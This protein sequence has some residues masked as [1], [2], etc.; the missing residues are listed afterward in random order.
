MEL[1]TTGLFGTWSRPG[2]KDS[3][4]RSGVEGPYVFKDNEDPGKLVLLLDYFGGDGYRPFEGNVSALG[5]GGWTDVSRTNWPT[6]L[7]HGSVV[8]VTKDRYDA[9]TAKW[10]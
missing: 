2:G 5:N 10:G 1:S 4:V 7:R 8:G 6:N 3:F 9:L